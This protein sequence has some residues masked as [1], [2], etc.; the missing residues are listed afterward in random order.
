[1]KRKVKAG[2]TRRACPSRCARGPRIQML[3]N[4]FFSRIVVIDAVETPFKAAMIAALSIELP[5]PGEC[6]RNS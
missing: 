5:I 4:P 1:M 6:M 2:P 3:R